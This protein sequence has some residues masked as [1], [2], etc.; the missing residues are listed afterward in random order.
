[1]DISEAQQFL[2][3]NHRGVLVTR[4]RDGSPQLS[5]VSATV[6]DEGRVVISTRET[7][8]KTHNLRRDRRTSLCGFTDDF[9]GQWAQVDGTAEIVGMPEAMELLVAAYRQAAG[10][11]PDWGDF[12]AAMVEQRRVAVRITIER[13]GPSRAG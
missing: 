3:T 11:H 12:R 5:P 6:D 8:M 4:R 10:E 1:M 13:A 9:Y 2:R 7:A